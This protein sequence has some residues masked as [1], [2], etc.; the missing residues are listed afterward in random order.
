[1][2]DNLEIEKSLFGTL[3]I[4]LKRGD[5]FDCQAED[6]YAKIWVSQPDVS[7]FIAMKNAQIYSYNLFS[8]KEI[9]STAYSSAIIRFSG[10]EAN[11]IEFTAYTKNYLQRIWI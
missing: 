6:E 10:L 8:K 3:N 11:S 4:S 5:R 2:V 7:T 9:Y 1:M